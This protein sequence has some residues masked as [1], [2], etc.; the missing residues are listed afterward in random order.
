MLQLSIELT[1]HCNDT[2][3]SDCRTDYNSKV[4]QE[5]IR[6]HHSNRHASDCSQQ[7]N[8]VDI[9]NQSRNVDPINDVTDRPTSD[10]FDC[11]CAA[12]EAPASS[13]AKC[14]QHCAEYLKA[15]ALDAADNGAC[16]YSRPSSCQ[17]NCCDHHDKEY[18]PL[19]ASDIRYYGTCHNFNTLASSNDQVGKTS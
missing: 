5:S 16:G 12:A 14:P 2:V 9:C 3:A 8:D 15:V 11:C 1:L 7:C 17:D 18:Y 13:Q 10:Q 19:F 4:Y 6:S